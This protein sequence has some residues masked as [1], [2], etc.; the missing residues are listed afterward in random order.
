MLMSLL[1]SLVLLLLLFALTLPPFLLATF[2]VPFP[3]LFFP[4]A[5]LLFLFFHPLIAG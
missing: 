4:S 2:F 5:L 3:V 1:V